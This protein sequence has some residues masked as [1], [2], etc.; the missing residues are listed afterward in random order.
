MATKHALKVL[1]T[2]AT[3]RQGGAVAR[4]LRERGHGVRA[5]TR[6]PGGERALAL[7]RAG[8]EIV[9]GDLEVVASL[10]SA[11]FGVDAVFA[12]ATPSEAGPAGETRQ[13]IHL[14]NAAK[15]SSDVKHFVYSSVASADRA[16]GIPH[17]ESKARVEEHLRASELPHTILAPVF[18]MENFTAPYLSRGLADGVLRMALRP[19]R[20]LQQ[21]SVH[22]VARFA[23]F[24]LEHRDRLLGR[25]LELAADN[26]DGEE[27]A[28]IL[29]E[30][31]GAPIRYVEE[32]LDELRARSAD[33]ASMFDYLDKVGYR[34]DPAALRREYSYI[35]WQGTRAWAA[36][37]DWSD[38]LA[39]P[40]RVRASA[41]DDV[42]RGAAT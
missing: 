42:G 9:G 11:L 2:G 29:G 16:T 23:V 38:V 27:T 3:G 25:R 1:V 20:K 15:A 10:D 22:D 28:A 21:V 32:P 37:V 31:I 30:A 6:S 17:F 41:S 35:G 19:R 4:I 36:G 14:V 34:A 40:R 24:A 18:F 33:M 39:P 5:L 8:I 26:L 13:A 7:A 12:V